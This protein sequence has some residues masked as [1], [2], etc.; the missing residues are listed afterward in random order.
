LELNKGPSMKYM[1]DIDMK[2]KDALT[3]DM[4]TFVGLTNNELEG[5]FIKLN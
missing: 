2:M 5:N 3:R 1:S 4:F